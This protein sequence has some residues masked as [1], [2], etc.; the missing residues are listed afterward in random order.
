MRTLLVLLVTSV[1]LA[2]CAKDSAG[3]DASAAAT[4]RGQTCMNLVNQ[5]RSRGRSAP[6]WNLYDYCMRQHPGG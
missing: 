5:E 1:I 2:G 3:R 4:P 6:N